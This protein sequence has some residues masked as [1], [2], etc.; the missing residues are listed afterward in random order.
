MTRPASRPFGAKAIPPA[1]DR[2]QSRILVWIALPV[3]CYLGYLAIRYAA[4]GGHGGYVYFSMVLALS[5]CFAL[6]AWRLQAAT[7]LAACYGGL[8]C[9][10]ITVLSGRPDGS[11]VFHSGLSPLILLFV[12]TFQATRLGRERK[13][14]R[15][16]AEPRGGRN[17]AQIVANLGIAALASSYC[18]V[19]FGPQLHVWQKW[20]YIVAAFQGPSLA[21]LAE[22]TADT[23]STEIGQAFGG[24]PFL[25]TT[26]HR[27]DPGTDGALSLNGTLAGVAS[28]A[29]VAAVGAPALGMRFGECM[30]V[31]TAAVAGLFFD[32]FLGATIERKGWIGNDLVNLAST[33]FAAAVALIALDFLGRFTFA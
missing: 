10:A 22:A 20:P 31:F 4:A 30:V 6:I 5:V 24:R 14:I 32:S 19:I 28:A 17:A 21:A 3:L 27:V 12:L 7:P 13:A 11:S 26:L 23:V 16:L 2:L 29:I 33:S 1:R 18:Y 9:L 25:F 8:I 15:G